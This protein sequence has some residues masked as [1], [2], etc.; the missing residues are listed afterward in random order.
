MLA[1]IRFLVPFLSVLCLKLYYQN[2]QHSTL[3]V[4][5]HWSQE[6]GLS[7]KKQNVHEGEI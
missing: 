4:V 6:L 7:H 2:V 5:L 1:V 3:S